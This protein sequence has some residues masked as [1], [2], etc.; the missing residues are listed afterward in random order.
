MVG[1]SMGVGF[2][3]NSDPGMG[4]LCTQAKGDQN[5]VFWPVSL[6]PNWEGHGGKQMFGVKRN[7]AFLHFDL[8]ALQDHAMLGWGLFPLYGETMLQIISTDKGC[9]LCAVLQM[10]YQN[11]PT[12]AAVTS[13]L[14]MLQV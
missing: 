4:Q 8:R 2:H 14:M 5:T 13:R 12:S 7:L 3:R 11:F 10:V 6:A 9:H 1:P